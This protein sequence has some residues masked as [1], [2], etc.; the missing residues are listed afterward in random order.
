M[1]T[2]GGITLKDNNKQVGSGFKGQGNSEF[3]NDYENPSLPRRASFATNRLF[4]RRLEFGYAE[5]SAVD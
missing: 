2:Q 3:P 5:P 1:D 4:R